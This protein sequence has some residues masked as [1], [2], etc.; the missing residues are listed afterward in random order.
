MG[1]GGSPVLF[2][3]TGP[4]GLIGLDASYVVGC[5]SLQRG[6]QVIGL[7]LRG[8]RRWGWGAQMGPSGPSL[9]PF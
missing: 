5:A 6:H 2:P 1:R 3:V 9:F 7:F 8:E 4:L